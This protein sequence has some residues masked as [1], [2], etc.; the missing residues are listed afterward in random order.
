MNKN[1]KKKLAGLP[2]INFKTANLKEIQDYMH[3]LASTYKPSGKNDPML[4]IRR[5]RG[6][7]C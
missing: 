3:K 5:E 6:H 2:D 1:H 4:V 7:R